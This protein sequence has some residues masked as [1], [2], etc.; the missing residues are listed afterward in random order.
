MTSAAVFSAK[1]WPNWNGPNADWHCNSEETGLTNDPASA[2]LLWLSEESDIGAVRGQTPR[3]SSQ[4]TERKYSS[5]AASPLVSNGRIYQ[6][7][8]VPMPETYSPQYV[9]R[10]IDAIQEKEGRE[11]TEN[12]LYNA[13]QAFAVLCKEYLLCIDPVDG[14]TIWKTL[15]RDSSLYGY[16]LNKLRGANN[17][18]CVYDGKVLGYGTT[19]YHWC[20]DA[21]TGDILWKTQGTTDKEE[22]LRQNIEAGEYLHE[23]N[24]CIL[25]PAVLAVDGVLIS[26]AYDQLLRGIDVED[27]SELWSLE[28]KAVE[29]GQ[30]F[31]RH[32][33]KTYL[34][35]G[36]DR[37][38][39]NCID[40]KTGAILWTMTGVADVQ[41]PVVVN[42]DYLIVH[43]DIT[44]TTVEKASA[45]GRLA[46]YRLNTEMPELLWEGDCKYNLNQ[47][48]A[49]SF[50]SYAYV[51]NQQF[52]THKKFVGD[53]SIDP[54]CCPE[55]ALLCFDITNGERVGYAEFRLMKEGFAYYADQK[56]IIQM[57]GN[58]DHGNYVYMLDPNPSEGK[59]HFIG[60]PL[61]LREIGATGYHGGLVFP[62]SD[63]RLIV[64]GFRDG[65]MHAYDFSESGVG[66]AGKG[67]H[68]RRQ[69]PVANRPKATQYYTI[70]G[71]RI[72]SRYID[73]G[74]NRRPIA[75]GV[76]IMQ[77]SD[78]HKVLPVLNSTN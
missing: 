14:S 61:D 37:G 31:W 47:C 27:G 72:D 8:L 65:Y 68:Q 59:L 21:E 30:T 76:Y 10:V 9:Q 48:T 6:Y 19:G 13:K 44:D 23:R 24:Q 34:M 58:H 36:H 60:D 66:V 16:D 41:Q 11:L 1:D 20:V 57:D 53:C 42:G 56:I 40:P 33:G 2:K 39:V 69:T 77:S 64:R 74:R 49:Y 28:R 3:K 73:F 43:H 63:G 22:R 5:G 15:L 71:R 12:E 51:R 25:G 26:G 17:T 38:E 54:P 18:P 29:F 7:Y 4:F 75:G 78:G 52:Q 35:S 50:G 32:E 45:T 62:L 67:L 70:R 46:G 55:S